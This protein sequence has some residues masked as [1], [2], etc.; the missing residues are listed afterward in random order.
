M[1]SGGSD[2]GRHATL[3]LFSYPPNSLVEMVEMVAHTD[4]TGVTRAQRSL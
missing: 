3:P 4:G 1:V 2:G